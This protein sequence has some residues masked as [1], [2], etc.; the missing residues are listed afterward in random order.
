VEN[1][2]TTKSI[3]AVK[4][5]GTSLD[6]SKTVGVN[7]PPVT[8]TQAPIYSPTSLKNYLDDKTK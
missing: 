1:N 8:S 2:C 7:A 6:F 3:E 4:A 5:G